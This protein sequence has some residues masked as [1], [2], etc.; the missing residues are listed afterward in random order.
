[1]RQLGSLIFRPWLYPFSKRSSLLQLSAEV[2]LSPT[3]FVSRE[4]CLSVVP[5]GSDAYRSAGV[6]TCCQLI[7]LVTL[8]RPEC[9]GIR[10]Q[11]ALPLSGHGAIH[12]PGSGKSVERMQHDLHL[13]DF[14]ISQMQKS[15]LDGTFLL[16]A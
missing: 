7:V 13:L 11:F 14:Q 8:T 9:K 4:P 5:K 15:N 16:S 12:G 10:D 6:F 2:F 1:M 3:F